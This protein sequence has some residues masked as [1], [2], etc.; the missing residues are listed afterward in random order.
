LGGIRFKTAL[1]ASLLVQSDKFFEHCAK[2]S[3]KFEIG[4]DPV[5][6]PDALQKMEQ[7]VAAIHAGDAEAQTL[8]L[9][10]HPPIY[11]A[12]TSAK[13]SDLLNP[14]F[15]VY[16]TGRGGQYTYHGPGQWLGY[17]MLDLKKR[18]QT[19]DLKLYIH[20]L[21]DWIIDTLKSFDVIGERREGRVGIWVDL[22]KYERKGEA[23][24]AAVGVRVRHWITYHGISFNNGPNLTH[25]NGIVPCGIS[26]FGVTSLAD[27]GIHV[28]ME[29]VAK[30]LQ[31]S[32][33]KVFLN[34]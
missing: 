15:P 21:E 3:M 28:S 13:A 17:V 29:D 33:Q 27:L 31:K 19:P 2:K 1:Q 7:C 34:Q 25:F 5:F 32:F 24:I 12:G 23:K 11:T 14:Q 30:E 9:C 16:E 20:N 4:P 22:K 18:Q 10:Q 26:E 6:Y 8:W